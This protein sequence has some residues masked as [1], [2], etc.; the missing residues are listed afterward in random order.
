MPNPREALTKAERL[1]RTSV[2]S[3]TPAEEDALP[4]IT[5]L[6][7]PYMF[8]TGPRTGQRRKPSGIK[9]PDSLQVSQLLGTKNRGSSE[10]PA[11]GRL[12][13]FAPLS[14]TGAFF[15]L[16]R[17]R[18]P[19]PKN[20]VNKSGCGELLRQTEGGDGGADQLLDARLTLSVVNSNRGGSA[21]ASQSLLFAAK[22]GIKIAPG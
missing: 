6:T 14:M 15:P 17:T 19:A 8:T 5:A 11:R 2:R 13:C 10:C 18:S 1:R 22:L 16:L 3:P 20:G 4:Q 12:R 9:K 7:Q 21:I